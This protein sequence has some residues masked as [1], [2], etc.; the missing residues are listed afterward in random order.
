[1]WRAAANVDEVADS[2]FY[3]SGPA[4]NWVVVRDG[5][6]F[7]LFDC[8]YP[9]DSLRLKES[10]A[11]LG[12]AVPSATAL[13]VT[14]AHND[15]IGSA[16]ALAGLGVPVW[17]SSAELPNL[18]GHSRHQVGL[19]DIYPHLWKPRFVG[20]TW[21]AVL[22]GGLHSCT[23]PSESVRTFSE[24][25]GSIDVPGFPVP[26]PTPGHTPGHTSYALPGSGVLI[27]GDAVVTGHPV[28]LSCGPQM[29]HDVYHSDPAAALS[30]A[31]GVSGLD[32]ES[33]IPG[34]GPVCSGEAMRTALS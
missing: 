34:H 14:H 28:S 6:E 22:A 8:G 9:K 2:V 17:C 18:T 7:S 27:A 19:H 11:Y 3:V 21:K 31:S 33:V 12:L 5:Q 20:W 32:I 29:L 13:L 1:M 10:L 30:S 4:S 25:P 15:H 23:L 16:R 26:V 24:S